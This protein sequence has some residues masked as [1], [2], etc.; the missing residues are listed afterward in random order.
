[1]T[2]KFFFTYGLV[3]PRDMRI[4]YIGKGTAD[5][6][7]RHFKK[8]P[9]HMQGKQSTR[10]SIWIE[11]VRSAGFEPSVI[12][13]NNFTNEQEALADEK[14][15]IDQ[16]GFDNLTNSNRGGGGDTSK[17]SKNKQP[18]ILSPEKEKFCQLIVEGQTQHDA[19]ISACNPTT[20]KST[21]IDTLASRLACSVQI[22][23]RIE[24]IKAP[25]LHAAQKKFS[26][27]IDTLTEQY[28]ENRELALDTSQPGAAN[29]STAG[30]AR[31]HQLDQGQG[32]T[33]NVNQQVGVQL[34]DVE[35]ARRMAT[36]LEDGLD[37]MNHEPAND[38]PANDEPANSSHAN[39]LAP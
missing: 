35:L 36:I 6:A 22:R 14:Q 18:S 7:R 19:Y 12:V 39:Y 24:E 25:A 33:I 13:F 21:S 38:E 30:I 34:G 16:L 11:E 8:V 32:T 27:T 20:I 4:H 26:A 28:I 2:I 15:R 23:S 31:L 37:A 1:M 17:K 3:D 10:K 9:R 5:R 29:G